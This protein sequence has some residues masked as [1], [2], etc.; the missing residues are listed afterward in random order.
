MTYQDVVALDIV[1]DEAM[2]VQ[3]AEGTAKVLEHDTS[4]PVIEL[5]V[6]AHFAQ[7]GAVD[8]LHADSQDLQHSS[9]VV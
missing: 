5:F 7:N 8:A 2:L 1:V 9:S 4:H 3:T 6:P